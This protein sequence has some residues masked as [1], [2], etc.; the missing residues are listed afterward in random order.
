MLGFIQAADAVL[1]PGGGAR[2]RKGS[3][4]VAQ[5]ER[6]LSDHDDTP[7]FAWVHLFDAHAPY[8]MDFDELKDAPRAGRPL[9]LPKYW[10]R[11]Y[12]SITSVDWLIDSYAREIARVDADV[13]TMIAALERKGISEDTVVVVV[14]DHGESLTEHESYFDHG[15]HLYDVSLRVPLIV[16]APGVA[17]AG[18]R[19]PCQLSTVDVA[20]SLLELAGVEPLESHGE[21]AHSFVALLQGEDCVDREVLSSTVRTRF[22]QNPP[23]DHSTRTPQA[24]RIRHQQG[25]FEQY[26]LSADPGETTNLV[27]S[28]PAL[29]ETLGVHF[30]ERLEGAGVPIEMERDAANI[31]AMRALGYVE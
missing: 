26:D 13:G 18:V 28:N 14:S 11:P 3:R 25:W 24:K 30:E 2:E 17:R 23:V 15:Q 31:E 7:F 22:V 5:F 16:K 8:E 12:R 1:L 9:P 10:P 27:A 19:V 6:F 4:T 29:I 21:F 20:P